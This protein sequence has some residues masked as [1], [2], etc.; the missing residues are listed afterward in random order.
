MVEL[1]LETVCVEA[2]EVVTVTVDWAEVVVV[3]IAVELD[4]DPE[5]VVAEAVPEE[6]EVDDDEEEEWA[7]AGGGAGGA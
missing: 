6:V 2:A 5:E 7:A 1:P 3:E 4:G